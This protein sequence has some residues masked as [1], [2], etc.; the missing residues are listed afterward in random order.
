MV[1]CRQVVDDETGVDM[2]WH[3]LLIHYHSRENLTAP[4]Y[5][6]LVHHSCILLRRNVVLK[7]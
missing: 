1:S 2:G 4:E 7:L 3:N 5:E 6:Y